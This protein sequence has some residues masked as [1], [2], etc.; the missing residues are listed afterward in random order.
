MERSIPFC[1]VRISNSLDVSS[2]HEIR[3]SYDVASPDGVYP[4]EEDAPQFRQAINQLAPHL[5][6]LTMRM[7][8]CMAIALG[9]TAK[10]APPNTDINLSNTIGLLCFFF[11]FRF[12]R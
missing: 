3:E 5:R 9:I 2:L 7:L 1:Y 8:K 6:E 10:V 4:N 11:L 12:G